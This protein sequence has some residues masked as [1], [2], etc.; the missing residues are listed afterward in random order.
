MA[1]VMY[2]VVLLAVFIAVVSAATKDA[3]LVKESPS[4]IKP[5]GSPPIFATP[6]I[7]CPDKE[8]VQNH[9]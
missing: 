4:E 3:R 2:G 8:R 1:V 7:V 6:Q 5:V 9:V